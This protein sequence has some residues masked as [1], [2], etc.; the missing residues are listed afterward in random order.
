MSGPWGQRVQAGGS[1]GR[2]EQAGVL[3]QAGEGKHSGAA[4]SA[5]QQFATWEQ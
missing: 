5:S 2:Q 4:A 3:Q 1:G